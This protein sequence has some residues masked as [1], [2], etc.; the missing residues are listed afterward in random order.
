MDLCRQ[1]FEEALSQAPYLYGQ[2]IESV[3]Q[4]ELWSRR[5]GVRDLISVI[6]AVL[7]DI[8]LLVLA[9]SFVDGVDWPGFRDGGNAGD[10]GGV[11]AFAGRGS[12]RG[13]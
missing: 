13:G 9:R 11:G 3:G 10:L 5:V 2:L 7:K 4:L 8:L 6:F 12:C 1:T